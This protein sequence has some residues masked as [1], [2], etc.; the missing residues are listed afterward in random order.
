MRIRTTQGKQSLTEL[1][2]RLFPARGPHAAE[3][4]KQAVAALRRA[5]P[6]LDPDASLPEGTPILV[7]DEAGPGPDLPSS[8]GAA[9]QLTEDAAARLRA[10][11]SGAGKLLRAGLE[12]ERK[13]E[14]EASRQIQQHRQ[15]LVEADPSIKDRLA[16][17]QAAAKARRDALSEQDRLQKAGLA[18]LFKDLD[19]LIKA[20]SLDGGDPPL[21]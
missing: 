21:R 13:R 20:A 11:L 10:A 9:L 14:E 1:A 19:E 17:I 12:A 5:N 8:R 18:Q 6:H 4:R 16:T 15:E 7:P 2:R 3:R